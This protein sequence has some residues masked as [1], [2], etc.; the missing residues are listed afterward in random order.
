MIGTHALLEEH[1]T[2]ADLG[3]VVVDEQHRFGVEQRAALTDK[4]GTPPHVLVMTA[5]P[6]PRTVAMTVFGDLEISTL[7]RAARRPGADPDQRRTARGAAALARPGLAA[8]PRGGR[9][10]PPGVRRVPADQRRRARAG[11]A[12]R[13]RGRRGGQRRAPKPALP[14][15]EELVAELA[16]GPLTGLR[17]GDAARPDAARRE[18]PTMRAFAA[19]DGRRAGLHHGDRGRRR[20][21]QRHHDGAARRRPVRRLPA[22]PA[23]RPGRPRRPPRAVPAGQPRRARNPRP[24]SGSTPWPPPPT[25][26]SSPGRPRAAP[27]GRRA[28]QL[29]VRLPVQPAEPPGAAR[30]EDDRRRPRGGAGAADR[31]SRPRRPPATRRGGGRAGGIRQSEF[32]EKS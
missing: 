22:P 26:S 25:A 11:R 2:F 18:G 1:V 20:R 8:G 32:M 5:T 10:G 3:L 17:V 30:R 24:A 4:A 15:V 29:A 27:R 12:R 13:R 14:A 21:P 19:G 16:E 31:R 23:P 7:H 6:I 9:Q 28:R